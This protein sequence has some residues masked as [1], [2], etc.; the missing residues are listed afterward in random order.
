MSN[1]Q[2]RDVHVDALDRHAQQLSTKLGAVHRFTSIRKPSDST[3]TRAT[4]SKILKDKKSMRRL[5]KFTGRLVG[6]SVLDCL[7]IKASPTL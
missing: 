1:P 6:S 4:D 7:E 5:G 2:A 3:A